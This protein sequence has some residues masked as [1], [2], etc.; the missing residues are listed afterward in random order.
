ML[1][2]HKSVGYLSLLPNLTKF[3]TI[4]GSEWIRTAVGATIIKQSSS[5]KAP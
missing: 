5:A 3:R 2:A 1:F 4:E